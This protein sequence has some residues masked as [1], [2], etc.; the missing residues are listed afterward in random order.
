MSV[1]TVALWLAVSVVTATFLSLIRLFSAPG[2][3]LGYAVLCVLSYLYI[4]FRLS[5]TKNRTLEQIQAI[6]TK[7]RPVI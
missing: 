4:W 1:A 2:V 7:G 6:W 5:E 3:F